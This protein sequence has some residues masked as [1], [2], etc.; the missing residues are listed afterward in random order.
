MCNIK[1]CIGKKHEY[2]AGVSSMPDTV[3]G[4]W[5]VNWHGPCPAQNFKWIIHMHVKQQIINWIII[6]MLCVTNKEANLI[7]GEFKK[8]A[9]KQNKKASLRK[10]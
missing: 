1:L 3:L 5:S 7:W 4:A 10:Q 2:P 8:Q 6:D 9:S